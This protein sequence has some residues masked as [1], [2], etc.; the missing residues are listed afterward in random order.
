MRLPWVFLGLGLVAFAGAEVPDAEE[1]VLDD[2][3]YRFCHEAGLDAQDAMTWCALLEGLPEE[4]C[5]GL[6]ETC[7]HLGE[8]DY[9]T[10]QE[11]GGCTERASG[12]WGGSD[13]ERSELASAP[14]KPRYFEAQGCE[15]QIQAPEG[16]GA[17][18]KWVVAGFVAAG[19][20]VL[21]RLLWPYLG[22]RR[23]PDPMPEVPAELQRAGRRR[24]GRGGRAP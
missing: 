8:D 9:G 22:F 17:L 18:L 15:Q 23:D 19:V 4:R 11:S 21:L 10:P 5:P 12:G 7:E 24:A 1:T 3:A 13:G 2:R 20:L 6:R 16:G 14:E